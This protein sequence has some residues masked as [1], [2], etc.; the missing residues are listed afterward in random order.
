MDAFRILFADVHGTR[1]VDLVPDDHDDRVRPGDVAERLDPFAQ[2][3]EELR[4]PDFEDCD[5]ARCVAVANGAKRV[6]CLLA[7]RVPYLDVDL[8][9]VHVRRVD[10]IIGADRV[11]VVLVESVANKLPEKRC[12]PNW[13]ITD[14]NNAEAEGSRSGHADT[15]SER[16]PCWGL[17][18]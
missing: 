2:V 10:L 18:F 7:G 9:V 16:M 11:R 3:A 8:G 4:V 17:K 1:F 12:L 13:L 5:C 15:I 6:I 14:Q